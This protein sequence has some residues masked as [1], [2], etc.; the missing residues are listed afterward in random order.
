ML[1]V[2]SKTVNESPKSKTSTLWNL[3]G[4]LR[5]CLAA[6]GHGKQKQGKSK[7]VGRPTCKVARVQSSGLIMVS[8]FRKEDWTGGLTA[9]RRVGSSAT[10]SLVGQSTSQGK[11]HM[12]SVRL[13]YVCR[14]LKV[15]LR[16]CAPL[17]GPLCNT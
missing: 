11:V 2:K 9:V 6:A 12:L 3:A 14:L 16:S 10:F 8:I 15:H 13:C 17:Q 1:S 4:S 5:S 7:P